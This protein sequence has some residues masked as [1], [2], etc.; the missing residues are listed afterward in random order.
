MNGAD[1][2]SSTSPCPTRIWSYSLR[3]LLTAAVL[4]SGAVSLQAQWPVA[5]GGRAVTDPA[6]APSGDV[7][8]LAEDRFLHGFSSQ[9]IRRWRFDV[10]T[11][12]AA[13]LAVCPAGP[14]V[15]GT[16]D[17]TVI[18]VSPAGSELWRNPG[19]GAAVGNPYCDEEGFVHV[20]S[21][22]RL[23][24]RISPA[25]NPVWGTELPGA[26][27]LDPVS[28]PDGV[29]F[30]PIAG[31]SADGGAGAVP[32]GGT[33]PAAAPSAAS[34]PSGTGPQVVVL[35]RDGVPRSRFPLDS[36]ATSHAVVGGAYLVGTETGELTV[37]GPDG[38]VSRL[39]VSDGAVTAV[40]A[41]PG[42]DAVLATDGAERFVRV[43]GVGDPRSASLTPFSLGLGPAARMVGVAGHSLYVTGRTGLYR[44]DN[45]LPT[46]L[47]GDRGAKGSAPGA[48]QLGVATR[49]GA[50]LVAATA[51]YG[52]AVVQGD[53]WILAGAPAPASAP[54]ETPTT[55]YAERGN[56]LRTGFP[57]GREIA[58]RSRE[59]RDNF[60]YLYL[61]SHLLSN[62]RQDRLRAIRDLEER[63][64]AGTLRGS[65][66][67][68][69]A[70][71]RR[72]AFQDF[73]GRSSGAV[74]FADLRARVVRLL[75]S[76]GGRSAIGDLVRLG[77]Y[78]FT[79]EVDAAILNAFAAV[80][81]GVAA[82]GW[83]VVEEMLRRHAGREGAAAV[84]EAAVSAVEALLA[85]SGEAPRA[86]EI[87]TE[88]VRG[89]YPREVRL[90][91]LQLF[92]GSDG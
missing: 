47:P 3:L 45:A 11:M 89:A 91:A 10:R 77:R 48:P 84:G 44:I 6:V 13:S 67:Y 43:A 19:R 38:R 9:G 53:E 41:G 49:R 31:S 14:I 24:R 69:V 23:L 90:R 72:A 61:Q 35:S 42:G 39:D 71:L 5:L 86:G 30:C 64:A 18:A 20:A 66:D 34:D 54:E 51:G 85:Y 4:L 80:P 92:E 79:A 15:L 12:P 17:G 28:G 46:A 52:M 56:A 76:V 32:D 63:V 75:G 8:V 36:E 58:P 65:A 81:A 7:Y 21:A 55:W 22:D 62:E 68:V 70:L 50:P 29:I 87:L 40:L 25:G 57:L 16:R 73:Q 74:G 83:D 37:Y 59:W 2:T 78:T 33:V 1:N 26:P 88:I 82:G 27:R 60:D